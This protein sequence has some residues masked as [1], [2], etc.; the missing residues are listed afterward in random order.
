MTDASAAERGGQIRSL[1][2][3]SPGNF[4]DNHPVEALEDTLRLF[5][6]GEHLGFDGAWRTCQR[7]TC[8]PTAA[9]RSA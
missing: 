5:D 8:S 3:L 6:L 4:P 2:F 1:S 7:P 9:F